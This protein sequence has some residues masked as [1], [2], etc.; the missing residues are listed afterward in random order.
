MISGPGGKFWRSYLG[1]P[2]FFGFNFS[3][4]FEF[5]LIEILF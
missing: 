3:F 5:C 2:F 4:E 1:L